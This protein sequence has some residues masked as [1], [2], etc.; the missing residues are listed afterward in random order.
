M[1]RAYV[2]VTGFMSSLEVANVLEGIDFE[3]SGRLLMVGVLVSSK[4]MQGIPNKWPGRYPQV[5]EVKNIFLDNKNCLNLVHFNTKEPD[6]LLDQLI[7]VTDIAGPH[8]DGFQL[9]IAWPSPAVLRKYKEARPGKTI[10]LQV[11]TNAFFQTSNSPEILANKVCHEYSGLIDYLLL[12]P[13]GGVGQSFDPHIA[14]EYLE[15]L[16]LYDHDFGIGV[17]GGLSASTLNL[18]EPILNDFPNVSI[19]A[20]GRLRTN[21]D[22]L[23]IFATRNY[24]KK[25]LELFE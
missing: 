11:G 25:S 23:D 14:R 4:T 24:L 6:S 2:G 8:F 1:K 10:V 17:A 18:L 9:N 7:E 21:I 5:E 19:D 13:S 16:D 3:K 22:N 15:S 20:E 12:D